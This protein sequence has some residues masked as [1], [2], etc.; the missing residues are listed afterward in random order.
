MGAAILTA[1]AQHIFILTIASQIACLL[2]WRAKSQP[3]IASAAFRTHHN[4]FIYIK[5]NAWQAVRLLLSSI[6]PLITVTPVPL[7]TWIAA[8]AALT[9]IAPILEVH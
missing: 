8:I 4:S 7:W 2:A 3:P 1:P 5:D 9:K 6:Q